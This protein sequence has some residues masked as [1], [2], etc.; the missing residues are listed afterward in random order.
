M[1]PLNGRNFAQLAL[2]VP[3][4]NTGAPGATNGG[5]FSVGGARSEQNAFQIDGTSNTDSYQNRVSVTP[6]IDGILEFKIQTN[7]Y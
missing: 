1:L 2:L 7:N 6:N 4:A 5:G 3:G